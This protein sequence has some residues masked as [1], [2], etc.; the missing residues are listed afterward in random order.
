MN[1]VKNNIYKNFTKTKKLLPKSFKKFPFKMRLYRQKHRTT[2]KSNKQFNKLKCSPYQNKN[3]DHELKDYTCY[4]RSN[5]QLFKNVWN[6]NSSDKIVTNNSREIWEYFK[7]K[8]D[9]QC[10]DELCW[11]KNTPLSKVNNSELLIKEIFKPFSPESWSS[12]PNTWLSSVDIIKK[13]FH[14]K[15]NNFFIIIY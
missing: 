9:K 5:L 12:K 14:K 11:L 13:Y 2:R 6:A 7:N 1:N 3:I 15:G 10:Y 8:L 4:S